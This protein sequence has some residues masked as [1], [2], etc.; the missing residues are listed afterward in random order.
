MPR[1]IRTDNEIK[2]MNSKDIKENVLPR[3]FRSFF[4]AAFF[5]LFNLQYLTDEVCY[6]HHHK[7]LIKIRY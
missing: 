1:I 5:T 2:K 4:G 7:L 3:F 6:M